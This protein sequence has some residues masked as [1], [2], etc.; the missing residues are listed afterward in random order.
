MKP[1]KKCAYCQ[2][3]FD[4]YPS[5][6]HRQKACS[7]PECQKQRRRQTNRDYRGKTRYDADYRR[8]VK[9]AWRQENGRAYMRQ[10]R[11]RRTGYV[12]RN[13]RQQLRRNERKRR[14]IV[15]KDVWK[16]LWCGKLVRIRILESDCKE[17][18]MRLLSD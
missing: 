18:L 13:R 15:K 12:K 1:R 8:E 5:Q 4:P 6:S 11:K 16:A 9:K 7:K 14:K 17:R 2:E 3:L 10:Y